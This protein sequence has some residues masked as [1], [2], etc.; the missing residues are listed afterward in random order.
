[1]AE[2]AGS[3]T[4]VAVYATFPDLA[5][6]ERI[7]RAVIEAGLA[8]CVNIVPGMRS[9]YRWKGAI[10][11]ADE[12]VG[13]FK[14]RADGADALCAAIAG[15][16]PYDTPAIVVLPIGGGDGRYLD[17]IVAETIAPR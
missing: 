5:V 10:E 3:G 13:L 2:G 16:H 15:R 7:G 17:W 11:A 6:A 4:T 1:M 8:A 12:V 9:I 14:T